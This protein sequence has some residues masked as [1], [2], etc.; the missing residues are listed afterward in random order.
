MLT[1]VIRRIVASIFILLGATFIAYILVA[2][3]GNPLETAQGLPNP[4][5]RAQTIATI[6]QTLNLN[7]NPVFRYFIWLKG[8]GGCVV[9]GWVVGGWVVGGC[10]VGG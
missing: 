8:V 1:F 5:Q 2:N 3:A 10:V 6:T 9:G 7:V 4:A